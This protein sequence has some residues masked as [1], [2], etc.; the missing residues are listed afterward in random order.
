[1][2]SLPAC[3]MA[4]YQISVKVMIFNFL[5]SDKSILQIF[6]NVSSNRQNNFSLAVKKQT[7]NQ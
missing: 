4:V 5:V 3:A 6:S 2:C 1:M 7:G